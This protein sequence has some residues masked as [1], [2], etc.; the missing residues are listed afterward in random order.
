[1]VGDPGGGDADRAPD[2]D[3]PAST[4]AAAPESLP[5]PVSSYPGLPGPP[6][7]WAPA[8]E[9]ADPRHRR[10]SSGPTW[11]YVAIA[12]GVV[13]LVIGAGA[14]ALL[15]ASG[16]DDESPSRPSA[17]AP[18]PEEEPRG[19]DRPSEAATTG[20]ATD[21]EVV[22]A[23]GGDELFCVDA[24]TGDEAWSE[25]LPSPGT[26]PVL[27][28]D[29]LV[30]A[31]DSTS[32]DV[33]GYSLD[34]D[35]LWE[36]AEVEDVDLQPAELGVATPPPAAGG[37]VAVAEGEAGAGAEVVGIDAETGEVAWRAGAASL[38]STAWPVSDGE[39]FYGTSVSFTMDVS[40][41]PTWVMVAVDAATGSEAWRFDVGPDPVFVDTAVPVGD[42]EAVAVRLGGDAGDRVVV[43]DSGSGEVR[44][45]A[46]LASDQASVAHVDGT[47]VVVDGARM[48]AFDERGTEVWAVDAP[49]AGNPSDVAAGVLDLVVLDGR[50]FAHRL[51]VFEVDPADGGA[52]QLVDRVLVDGLAVAADHLVVVGEGLHGFPL[53][54]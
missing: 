31:T 20:A 27:V 22:C 16:G 36:S 43:L 49:G 7:G 44:W 26:P 52:A 8:G 29:T 37:V 34:G 4:E 12:T 40:V 21:G 38:S 5:A 6:A 2:G 45:E 9:R 32:G 25:E 54:R 10:P 23:T 35:L 48:R 30:V 17:A 33:R 46:L 19:W 50:L 53:E 24:V 51:D 3:A 28:G 1:V 47:T 13:A 11:A 42:G 14:V 39:R 15:V 18:E 41:E